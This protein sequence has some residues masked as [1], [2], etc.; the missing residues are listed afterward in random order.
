[1]SGLKQCII[2][3][4]TKFQ[5]GL[6]SI[7]FSI[8]KAAYLRGFEAARNQAALIAERHV[9]KARTSASEIRAS[10]I[11]EAIKSMQP[12]PPCPHKGQGCAKEDYCQR[13]HRKCSYARCFEW[14]KLNDKAH[15]PAHE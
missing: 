1:M 5:R 13:D 15:P 9:D 10:F 7:E 6:H 14:L 12:A 2:D 4:E 3:A 8:I 11:E